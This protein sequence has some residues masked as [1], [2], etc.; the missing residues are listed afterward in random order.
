ML[1]KQS[2]FIFSTE[3]MAHKKHYH[4]L[5]G[6]SPRRYTDVAWFLRDGDANICRH[7]KFP[8]FDLGKPA[9]QGSHPGDINH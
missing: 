9:H 7:K 6:N 1:Y 2:Q 5:V 4:L 3:N 8:C